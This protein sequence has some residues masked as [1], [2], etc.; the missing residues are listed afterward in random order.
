MSTRKLVRE[1][2]AA[3]RFLRLTSCTDQVYLA[4]AP[5][6]NACS[7]DPGRRSPQLWPGGSSRAIDDRVL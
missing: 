1:S 2:S 6:T 4:Q 3:R 7:V 5:R